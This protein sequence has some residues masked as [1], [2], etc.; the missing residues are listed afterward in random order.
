MKDLAKRNYSTSSK[1]SI[2]RGVVKIAVVVVLV[3]VVLVFVKSQTGTSS[4]NSSLNSSVIL[5]EA[6]RGLT[7]VSIGDTN[8]SSAGVNLTTQTANMKIVRK[9][10]TGSVKASRTYGA[11]TYSL[12][13]TANIE[14]PKGAFYQVWLTDGTKLVPIDYMRGSGS[15]WSLDLSDTDKY[16]KL[17]KIWITLERGK[18]NK[19]EEHIVEGSF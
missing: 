2:P 13:V 16:S 4:G 9:E 7:P 18:D 15:S 12:S 6:P 10:V 8:I 5:S 19:P 11:G 14:D 1:V 17:N 3:L